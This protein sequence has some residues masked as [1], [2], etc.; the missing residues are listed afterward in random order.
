[1]KAEVLRRSR[2]MAFAL[3][4]DR[5]L[6]PPPPQQPI[7]RRVSRAAPCYRE[8]QD[9]EAG[10]FE[11]G[12]GC[13]RSSW[14]RVT[15]GDGREARGI[16]AAVARRQSE[17]HQ[18]QRERQEQILRQQRLLQQPFS[19]ECAM[20]G[21][22][23]NGRENSPYTFDLSSQKCFQGLSRFPRF[24]AA[25]MAWTGEAKQGLSRAE[26]RQLTR[27][28]PCSL[29]AAGMPSGG[30]RRSEDE[31][32]PTRQ[33]RQVLPDYAAAA[34]ASSPLLPANEGWLFSGAPRE[35]SR[36]IGSNPSPS[37][38][39]A[40]GAPGAPPGF[41]VPSTL[42]PALHLEPEVFGCMYARPPQLESGAEEVLPAGLPSQHWTRNGS[43][44]AAVSPSHVV[45]SDLQS[46]R[47]EKQHRERQTAQQAEKQGAAPFRRQP[48]GFTAEVAAGKPSSEL[49]CGIWGFRQSLRA[50]ED[51]KTS[52]GRQAAHTR[53]SAAR[54]ALNTDAKLQLNA[55][56]ATVGD[57]EETLRRLGV[58]FSPREL[59]FFRKQPN[60]RGAQKRTVSGRRS[61]SCKPTGTGRAAA[62]VPLK[63][64]G[65]EGA[66]PPALSAVKSDIC[67]LP[68]WMQ[69]YG[70]STSS[71]TPPT[72]QRV[73]AQRRFPSSGCSA[74]LRGRQPQEWPADCLGDHS[75]AGW[76]EEEWGM[77][78]GC[79]CCRLRGAPASAVPEGGLASPADLPCC[80]CPSCSG[81]R[82]Q[83]GSPPGDAKPVYG[84]NDTH[85]K[86][87]GAA[88]AESRCS[89][90]G[91]WSLMAPTGRHP[92][93][94]DPT[95][96][97]LKDRLSLEQAAS[98]CPACATY[99]ACEREKAEAA[100]PS[101]PGATGAGQKASK[102]D[103]G[104]ASVGGDHTPEDH[105]SASGVQESSL[106]STPFAHRRSASK[107]SNSRAEQVGDAG[108]AATAAGSR[109]SQV[110]AGEV[111]SQKRRSVVAG[112]RSDHNNR[113]SVAKQLCAFSKGPP[114]PNSLWENPRIA[115]K[116]CRYLS[117]SKLLLVRRCNKTLLQAAQYRMRFILYNSLFVLM[118]QEQGTSAAQP[119]KMEGLHCPLSAAAL[120]QLLGLQQNE[121]EEVQ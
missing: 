51:I 26:K 16:A 59:L 82:M 72:L 87:A 15:R 103:T 91:K 70:V 3:C 86:D 115:S 49:A 85:Q 110:V 98:L 5:P 57:D 6:P 2:V 11:G 75:V 117:L 43:N 21:H 23:C 24:A 7:E 65:C 66:D 37:G 116:I 18:Q 4:E 8:G 62:E 84:E 105:Y 22:L 97:K 17:L 108:A 47:Q 64:R 40:E 120:I 92:A 106:R 77:P 67:A 80:C 29:P 39:Y 89:R 54:S 31:G 111:T 101:G 56:S 9:G 88:G 69:A 104:N 34:E 48:A 10:V 30:S 53:S 55:A 32:C 112:K 90:C 68:S 94:Q 113:L 119:V 19:Y 79:R 20:E 52:V 44:N 71:A 25:P 118:H 38:D 41:C 28:S 95:P 58:S 13:P 121:V 99:L 36:Q 27:V 109:C 74:I 60:V 42:P 46:N 81:W 61:H 45:W 50:P 73:G 107:G 14:R 78:C 102:P 33:R 63:R 35:G 12:P 1:M 93:H 96:V 114:E 76:E 100:P 83:A